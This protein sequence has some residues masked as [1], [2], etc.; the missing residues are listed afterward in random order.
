MALSTAT[1]FMTRFTQALTDL[2]PQERVNLVDAWLPAIR[3]MDKAA[4]AG[5]S[6]FD[7]HLVVVELM[8]IRAENMEKL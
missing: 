7:Q 5:V 3:D 2:S 8:T 4:Q 1:D 6:A